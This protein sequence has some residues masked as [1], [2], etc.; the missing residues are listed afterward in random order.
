MTTAC[1]PEPSIFSAGTPGCVC[2][3]RRRRSDIAAAGQ[4]NAR[5]GLAAQCQELKGHVPFRVHRVA[6]AVVKS[7]HRHVGVVALDGP[8]LEP[9]AVAARPVAPT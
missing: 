7:L 6:D 8:L 4:Q 3:D 9:D 5:L 1:G 2:S